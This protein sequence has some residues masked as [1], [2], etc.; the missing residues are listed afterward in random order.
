MTTFSLS[1]KQ[2]NTSGM[3]LI[4]KACASL[5]A[6]ISAVSQL[7]FKAESQQAGERHEAN[8]LTAQ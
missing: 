6:Q 3:A 4:I 2:E 7:A 1:T 8:Y 5:Q